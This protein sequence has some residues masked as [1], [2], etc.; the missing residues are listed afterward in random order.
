MQFAQ[1]IGLL[2]RHFGRELPAAT[3]RADLLAPGAAVDIPAAFQFNQIAAVAEDDAGLHQFHD[4]F[5]ARVSVAGSAR[6]A[7]FAAGS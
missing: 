3:A 7:G 4:A 2:D 1:C 6:G 5:H